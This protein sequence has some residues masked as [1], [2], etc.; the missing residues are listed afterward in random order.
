MREEVAALV[1]TITEIRELCD[2]LDNE[3]T[4]GF[5]P[6]NKYFC[7]LIY[8]AEMLSQQCEDGEV[9]YRVLANDHG[10]DAAASAIIDAARKAGVQR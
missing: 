6:D 9:L 5:I 4:T 1:G 8:L 10:V 2:E 7:D 3:L